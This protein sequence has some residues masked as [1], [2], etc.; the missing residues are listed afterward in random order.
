[1]LE[2]ESGCYRTDQRCPVAHNDTHCCA[3]HTRK[4]RSWGLNNHLIRL[5]FH[6]TPLSSYTAV[7]VSVSL[8]LPRS[9]PIT[10]N[11]CTCVAV[12][13]HSTGIK[14]T[15][16]ARQDWRVPSP[17]AISTIKASIN[18]WAR[19]ISNCAITS[20][21]AFMMSGWAVICKVSITVSGD[22]HLVTLRWTAFGWCCFSDC[23]LSTRLSSTSTKSSAFAYLR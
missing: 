3:V 7:V 17:S 11:R 14:V 9:N 6:L 2:F 4:R 21:S 19:R 22:H 15:P 16:F 12:L 13:N 18:T 5:S 20:C 8:L 23:R 1:M 10:T